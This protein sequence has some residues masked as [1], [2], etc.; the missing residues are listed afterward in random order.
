MQGSAAQCRHVPAPW[1]QGP[2][3]VGGEE[4]TGPGC[5]GSVALWLSCLS[6]LSHV[7]CPAISTASSSP[8]PFLYF[9][10]GSNPTL[11]SISPWHMLSL[12]AR[13]RLEHAEGS[14]SALLSWGQF[15]AAAL[16][17][18]QLLHPTWQ[19]LE[20]S[21]APAPAAGPVGGGEETWWGSLLLPGSC[22]HCWLGQAEPWGRLLC[23]CPAQLCNKRAPVV[24]QL[25][26]L[27]L[28][29]LPWSL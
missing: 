4:K 16:A 26:P 1:S 12:R 24:R 22:S 10:K 14:R 2:S 17:L 20:P 11:G 21:S 25:P 13:W 18:H 7:C 28:L 27:A 9:P 5:A 3:F 8:C 23:L 6:L 15:S 19:C 29:W